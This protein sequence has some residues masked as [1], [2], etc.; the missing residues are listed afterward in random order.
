MLAGKS[1]RASRVHRWL[2]TFSLT[3]L[4]KGIVARDRRMGRLPEAAPEIAAQSVVTRHRIASGRNVLDAV[5]VSPVG[6]ADSVLLICHGIGETVEYWLA[7][8]QFL[9]AHGAVTLVFDYSGYGRSTGSIGVEQL[10]RDA[11]AAFAFLQEQVPGL[12]VSIMGFSLGSGI[13]AAV[14]SRVR[15][16]RLVLCASFTSFR[17]AALSGGLPGWM[18][19]AVPPIWHSAATVGDCAVPVMIVH[20]SADSLF[21]VQMAR[22]L[23]G[24]CGQDSELVVVPGVGHNEPYLLPLLPYWGPVLRWIGWA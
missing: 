6:K 8:Q 4:S 20:G 12:P 19:F 11:E 13:A 15:A 14:I 3:C 21:P 17:D 10:E 9:A 18:R 24:R 16:A 7:T 2:F 22:E 5:M 1:N 23:H